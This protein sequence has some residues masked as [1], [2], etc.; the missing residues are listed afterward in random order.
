MSAIRRG[1]EVEAEV[2][3]TRLGHPVIAPLRNAGIPP[4]D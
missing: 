3:L 1:Y 2:L 4:V